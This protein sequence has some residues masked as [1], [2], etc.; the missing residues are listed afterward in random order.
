MDGEEVG[1]EQVGGEPV[2]GS[3]K[4]RTGRVPA[5]ST[6]PDNPKSRQKQWRECLT[7]RTVEGGGVR[8]W[9]KGEG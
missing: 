9:T 7:D 1:K 5:I 4:S 3:A 6:V 8:A 2:G